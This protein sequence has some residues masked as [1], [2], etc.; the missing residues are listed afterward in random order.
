MFFKSRGE[1]EERGLVD[2][3]ELCVR[4]SVY[5]WNEDGKHVLLLKSWAVEMMI[6]EFIINPQHT[7]P[8]SVLHSQ[9]HHPVAKIRRVGPLADA[10][11]GEMKDKRKAEALSWPSSRALLSAPPPRVS[12][13]PPVQLRAVGERRRDAGCPNLVHFV[14][15][16]SF[17][18]FSSF[19]K[20]GSSFS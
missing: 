16:A 5:K 8:H 15:T 3:V 4:R 18:R 10:Y 14:A 1:R 11:N 20:K 9:C 7:A 13:A 2:M 19:Q 6:V 12:R 17:P